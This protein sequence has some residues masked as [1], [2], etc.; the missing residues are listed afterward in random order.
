[1]L[2]LLATCFA[3]LVSP[4]TAAADAIDS[5]NFSFYTAASDPYITNLGSGVHSVVGSFS[6]NNGVLSD[7]SGTF[8]APLGGWSLTMSDLSFFSGTYDTV[9]GALTSLAFR[10]YTEVGEAGYYSYTYG[11][12]DGDPYTDTLSFKK[13]GVSG[14]QTTELSASWSISSVPEM[15]RGGFASATFLLISAL[16]WLILHRRNQTSARQDGLPRAQL[17]T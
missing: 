4:L 2:K 6:G 17:N 7:F 8:T 3:I 10:F 12:G 14:F 15:D 5:F 11:A 9:S 1:M 13:T 16:C